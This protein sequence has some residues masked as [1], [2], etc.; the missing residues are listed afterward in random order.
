MYLTM[1][2]FQVVKEHADAFEALWVTRDS[3]LKQVGGFCAF[4]LLKGP[5]AADHILYTSHTTWVDKDSFLAWTKSDAFR[6]AHGGA[7]SSA[8]MYLGP[9]DLECFETIQSLTAE[10][11]N[12]AVRG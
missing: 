5:E 3:H 2:R 4:H 6:Q 12:G 9:P 10:S 7:K 1:N 8:H 11:G